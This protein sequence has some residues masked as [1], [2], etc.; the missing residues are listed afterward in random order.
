MLGAVSQPMSLPGLQ[1]DDDELLKELNEMVEAE[2]EAEL[3]AQ[4][5][6]L[7]LPDAPMEEARRRKEEEELAEIDMLQASMSVRVESAMPAALS[8]PSAVIQFERP[9]PA[10][11]SAMAV[12]C[13]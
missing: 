8:A 7:R 2:A 9:M 5:Q 1:Q 4:L 11:S 3:T 13:W 6:E 10:L 12:A